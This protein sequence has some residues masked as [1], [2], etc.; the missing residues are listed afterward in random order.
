MNL[1]FFSGDFMYFVDFLL[2]LNLQNQI[3]LI[4]NDE[5]GYLKIQWSYLNAHP[6]TVTISLGGS[7]G[8][9]FRWEVSTG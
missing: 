3:N 5:A 8:V 4:Q 7:C 1:S 2:F 6:Q 9:W